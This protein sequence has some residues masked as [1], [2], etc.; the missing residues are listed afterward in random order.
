[1]RVRFDVKE[2]PQK[3]RRWRGVALDTFDN[4]SWSKS[5]LT[6]KEPFAKDERGLIQVNFASSR[7]TLVQQTVY[8]EP[9]DTPVI[10]SLP[11]LIAVQSDLPYVFRDKY[12]SIT[13]QGR[14]ERISYKALSDVSNPPIERLRQDSSPYPRSA[15]NYLQLPDPIDPRIAEL[16][17]QFTKGTTNRYDAAAAIERHLQNDFDYTLEQKAGGDDPLADFLFNVREGHCEYFA[18]AMA[19]MLRTQGIATR[20]VNGF[21]QG[22]YNDTADIWVVRQLNAHSWVEVYFPAT[23]T[24]ETF[25]PTPFG[26]QGGGAAANGIGAGLSKYMEAL[27]TFWIQYFVAFDGQEQRSLMTSLR[28]GFVSYQ[29]TA[30]SYIS[31]A[32]IA[33]TGWW[34]EL[35]GDK[36]L[37]FSIWA[38]TRGALYFAALA[39]ILALFVWIYRKIVELKVWRRLYDRLFKRRIRSA[40]EFYDRLVT[41]LAKRGVVRAEHQ[42]PLEFAYEIGM[43]QAVK[44]TQKYNGVRFGEKDLSEKEAG[45]IEQWLKDLDNLDE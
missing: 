17:A 38:A 1:M 10:F 35:R 37:S 12:D 29:E 40:V 34:S 42:T 15:A 5:R 16:A 43:P 27:E 19:M 31:A 21:S 6:Q 2:V 18:T 25:D 36:G 9:L 13:F 4:L 23:D 11:K 14:G 39:V 26:G 7:D 20:V 8:L 30:T 44:I 41:T 3:T 22:E 45:E 33:I 24:W 28:R 32:K